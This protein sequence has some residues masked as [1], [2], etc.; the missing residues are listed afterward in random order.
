MPSQLKLWGEQIPAYEFA[1]VRDAVALF[2]EQRTGKTFI[3]MAILRKLAGSA[4]DL[5]T[6][7]GNDF[8]GVLV[9]LL[10]N[11]DSTWRD[12]LTEFLPWLNVTDDWDD[13]KKLPCPRL[14]LVHFERLPRLIGKLVKFKKINW[15]G[16]DEAHRISKRGTKQSR[17]AAR[18]SWV[19]RKLILTGT[20]IEK[21][22]T[23]LFAQ[24]RFL[25]PDVFGT[26]WEKFE[27]EYMEFTKLNFDHTPRGSMAWQKRIMQQRI[28]RSKAKFKKSKLRKLT[29]LIAPYSFRLTKL[30]VG[31][32][33]PRVLKVPV[34][35][36][37][38]QRRYYDAMK[39]HSVVK[40][41]AG[42]RAL[43]EL[44]VTNIMKRRQ[45]ASGFVYDD[46]EQV[47]HVGD[48][49]LR[50][51]KALFRRLPK[52]VV[53]FTAFRPDNDRI[54][55]ELASE[56]FD[57]IAVHGGVNKKLR[58]Q[59]W[60]SFQ[61]AQYDGIICQT[62]T[63]GVGVDLWKASAAIVH[64]MGHSSIDFDQLKS[65]LDSKAKEK[66]ADIYVLCG[67]DTIDEELYDL[68]IVKR[69][70]SEEVLSKLRRRA[71][72]GKGKEGIQVRRRRHRQGVRH[73]GDQRPR[74][75]A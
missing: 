32:L 65:R 12:K 43:A 62:K 74:R 75:S 67:K 45:L 61:R 3:T 73:Q 16:I 2:S 68:V 8:C 52:P 11:R 56:G 44:E 34:A 55:R 60:R 30:D 50:R 69:L 17:A 57:V 7:K 36:D 70:N 42:Q 37:G 23:D 66:P 33:E 13:F 48:A 54:T 24:F 10:N 51:L 9:C 64:S 4:I 40:L 53:I 71:S 22:P 27:D 38:R 41:P 21:Q 58:P 14:L 35:I 20:P 26:N 49:K 1:I 19:P 29:R 15:M 18:M 39:R 59:I 47:H 72:H 28:L 5:T 63:G 6:G 46:E 31:I 25:D